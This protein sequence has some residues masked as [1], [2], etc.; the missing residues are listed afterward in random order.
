MSRFA[1]SLVRQL[2]H[3]P[4]FYKVLAANSLIVVAGA[5]VGTTLTLLSTGNTEHLPEFVALFA[6]SGTLLSVL[7]NWIVL[8]AAFRP[9]DVLEQ[10][11]DEVRRGNFHVRAPSVPLSDPDLDNL[12]ATFNAMLDTLVGYQERLRELSQRV[13]TAQEEERR[14]IA[15][16][17]HD[18]P[19]QSLTV[20][21]VLLKMLQDRQ[22]PTDGTLLRE[23]IDLTSATLE[24]IR[25]IAQEL[26]PPV[27]DD[28]GLAAALEGLAAQYRQRF[29]LAVQVQV[30]GQRQRLA[31]DVELALYRI[32]QEALTN[33]AKHASAKR[34]TMELAFGEEVVTLRIEDDGHGFEPREA[35]GRGLGLFGMRERAQLV[36]GTFELRA[37]P[38]KG[39]RIDVRVP[40]EPVA[41]LLESGKERR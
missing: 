32:A 10:T 40:L 9:I 28:L 39:T 6:I 21:L 35:L 7:I 12:T 31:P 41:T 36:H 27:L 20:L 25:T 13:L 5:V 1:H 23:L 15:R 18:D 38:G 26:R 30:R 4:I 29:G 8:R 14:R 22:Q 24:S 11:A 16:E 37:A 19:A 3:L 33:V 34:A 2:S 17:L